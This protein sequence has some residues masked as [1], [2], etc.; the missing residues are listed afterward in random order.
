M[1]LVLLQCIAAIALASLSLGAA[2]PVH[3]I[4]TL[5]NALWQTHMDQNSEE[6]HRLVAPHFV[7][8]V[9]GESDPVPWGDRDFTKD[10]FKRVRYSAPRSLLHLVP[11]GENSATGAFSYKITLVDTDEVADMGLWQVKYTFNEE[12]LCTNID[13][14]GNEKGLHHL[15]ELLAATDEEGKD[16]LEAFAS[17]L[18]DGDVKTAAFL[19]HPQ[20][21]SIRNGARDAGNWQSEEFLKALFDKV[22]FITASTEKVFA[23]SDR[24]YHGRIRASY[25]IKSTGATYSFVDVC[26]YYFDMQGKIY[27]MF[28]STDT[29]TFG[30]MYAVTAITG[31]D[32]NRR[33]PGDPVNPKGHQY[34]RGAPPGPGDP[35]H[36][37]PPPPHRSDL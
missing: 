16:K 7:S 8:T 18:K 36:P 33:M 1:P 28:C 27:K 15:T 2:L 17:A 29:A 11:S 37:P 6:F 24:V 23:V 30:Q 4:R 25:R 5:A 26:T 12:K 31:E 13:W 14:I 22:E 32:G 9:N 19:F 10:Y 3:E 21:T 20:L 34:G 35:R